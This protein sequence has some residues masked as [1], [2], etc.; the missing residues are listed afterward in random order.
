MMKSCLKNKRIYHLTTCTV[1]IDTENTH[2]H[3]KLIAS[4]SPKNMIQKNEHV[5]TKCKSEL[6]KAEAW[7]VA[8]R[9]NLIMDG[10]LNVYNFVF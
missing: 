9:I 5:K 10:M 4:S 8:Q 2:I 3:S 7:E 1:S 6:Q